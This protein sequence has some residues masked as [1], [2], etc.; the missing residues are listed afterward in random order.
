MTSRQSPPSIFL[1]IVLETGLAIVTIMIVGGMI[2][3][4]LMIE[5]HYRDLGAERQP[6]KERTQSIPAFIRENQILL[7]NW[8]KFSGVH[9]LDFTQEESGE[10]VITMDV[11]SPQIYWA[12]EPDVLRAAS[13]LKKYPRWNVIV[14]DGGDLGIDFDGF[15]HGFE[16][17][18]YS[19]NC[20]ITAIAIG[21]LAAVASG[22]VRFLI[23]WRRRQ[24]G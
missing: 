22:F 6:Q 16:N 2:F 12:V 4:G 10:L 1:T 13:H 9:Q 23:R 21:G 5:W 24:N 3:S 18:F 20:F 19:A 17:L 11:E 7:E 8:R 14:R 15:E